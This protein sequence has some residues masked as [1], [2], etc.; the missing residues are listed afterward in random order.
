M[1]DW[2]EKLFEDRAMLH[3]GHGQTLPDLNLGLGWVYYG[4]VR[5]IRPMRAVVIGSWRGFVPL[6]VGKAMQDNGQGEVIFIDPSMVDDFWRKPEAVQSHFARCRVANIRHSLATT[7]DFVETEEY[8]SLNNVGLL[9]I[10]GYHTAEQARFDHQAF[11]PK[12]SGSAVTLFHDSVRAR[13]SRMYGQGLHY[14]HSV[15]Q[16]MDELRGDPLWD[17]LALSESDGLTIVKRAP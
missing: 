10:D 16:Y 15:F 13:T 3:M 8:R 1:Q 5:S 11:L 12:M 7:Q 17:V 14:E 9:F 2:I 4:L 6:V